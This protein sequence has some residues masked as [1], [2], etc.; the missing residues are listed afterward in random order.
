MRDVFRYSL[1]HIAWFSSLMN[2]HW[3]KA[4]KVVVRPLQKY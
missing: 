1:L 3:L 4:I 2:L